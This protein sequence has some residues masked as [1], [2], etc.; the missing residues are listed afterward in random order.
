MNR[1]QV[2]ELVSKLT[3]EEKASLCS[4][5]TDWLTT[6]IERLNIPAAQM[7]DGPHG[8][9]MPYEEEG[10]NGDQPS[11]SLPAECAAAA[12][13]DRDLL[14]RI[15]KTLGRECQA[16][17][18]QMIL[19]PGVNMKRSPLCGRNFEYLSEDPLLA[20]ELGA[21]YVNGVQSQGVGACVKHFLAN[22]QETRRMVSSSEVDDRTM[23][24]IYM[25]TFETVVKKAKPWSI[26]AS[27]NKIN[28]TYATESRQ[29]LTDVLRGEWGF[30]GMAVSD[31]GA[32]HDRVK[33]VAAGCDLTMPSATNTDKELVEA[34]K[35]GALPESLLDTA[36]ENVLFFAIRGNEAKKGGTFD[37]AA[38]HETCV[39]AAEE[40]AVL[41]KNDGNVLPIREGKTV[42]F[43]GEFAKDP[44]FQGGGSSHIV[45]EHVVSPWDAAQ[46]NGRNADATDTAQSCG[47]GHVANS[48]ALSNDTRTLTYARG[49]DGVTV[50]EKLQAEAVEAAKQADVAVV[51]AGLPNMMETEGIDRTHMAIPDSHNALVS[52]VAAAQPNTVVVLFNGSPIEMPWVDE[53]PAI[54]EMYLPG[55]GVGE[56]VNGILFGDVNPS[57]H[58][59]ETFPLRLEDNPSYLYYFGNKKKVEYREG[60]FIGYRHYTSKKQKVLFPF[61]HG[62]SYTTFSYDNLVVDKEHFCADDEVKVSVDVKNS[63]AVAGKAVVQVYIGIKD[64]PDN[65]RPIRTL[66]E[67]AKMALEPGETKT[68]QFTLGKRAF[69]Y[70]NEEAGCYHLAGG[71]Y[72]VQ[73]GLSAEEIVLSKEIVAEEEPLDIQIDY[74]MMTLIGDMV[75]HPAGKQFFES[76]LDDIID[77]V[78]ASGIAAHVAGDAI[79][80]MPREQMRGMAAGMYGQS[81]QTL[82]MFLPNVQDFEWVQ[83]INRLNEKK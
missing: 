53:V 17:G 4:G 68:V 47:A 13:F 82:C 26:M 74:D 51:F 45:A 12:S 14:Y 75:K 39:K 83:L 19:G 23:R 81:I 36:A 67:F 8:L 61:G 59:P 2:K 1:E 27:Y 33:A 52:A 38:D 69:A 55:E 60:S 77:G 30:D 3:L 64:V 11:V 15:G 80:K 21:A 56:A 54:L 78:I 63:G 79:E 25:P 62:L 48:I 35:A 66:A 22:S 7:N 5:A 31:W 76:H 34:V 37:F 44:R 58:L 70:W 6:A 40:C 71:T 18:V 28:G 43:I 42:A 20:G 16:R 49:Y 50:N 73:I 65:P 24:E 57:G 9:R 32:T 29:F 10:K 72:E 46:A 41:L